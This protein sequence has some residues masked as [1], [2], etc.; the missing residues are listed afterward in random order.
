MF[1]LNDVWT[2]TGHQAALHKSAVGD[3]ILYVQL[4]IPLD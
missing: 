2:I 4:I 3:A 1:M